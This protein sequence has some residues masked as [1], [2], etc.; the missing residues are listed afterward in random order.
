MKDGDII[1]AP[2]ESWNSSVC[3]EKEFEEYFLYL[4]EDGNLW[5]LKVSEEFAKAWIKEF[6]YV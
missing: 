4:E 5:G 2:V 6:L 3:L 1:Y